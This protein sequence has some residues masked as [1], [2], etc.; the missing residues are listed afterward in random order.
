MTSEQFCNKF[1][2]LIDTTMTSL[3]SDSHKKRMLS[4]LRSKKSGKT[5]SPDVYHIRQTFEISS[6]FGVERIQR[7]ASGKI[8]IT[9][10]RVDD[11]ISAAHHAAGTVMNLFTALH[12]S[13]ILSPPPP[14]T[15]S[16]LPP[17]SLRLK[18][19]RFSLAVSLCWNMFK[20]TIFV[21]NGM[22]LI[23]LSLGRSHHDQ[24]ALI[25]VDVRASGC[26]CL[27]VSR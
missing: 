13:L 2:A 3:L 24:R 22:A 21:L 20:T 1:S 6:M 17:I 27:C 4:V 14:P 11:T 18:D 23:S 26:M 15:L 19:S 10:P 8:L 9:K 25:L 12:S 16:P 7:K 5:E